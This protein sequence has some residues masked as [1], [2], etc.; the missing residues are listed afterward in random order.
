MKSASILKIFDRPVWLS[1]I[2]M[3]ASF[4]GCFLFRSYDYNGNLTQ[5]AAT[6]RNRVIDINPS[7]LL[8][9]PSLLWTIE[10]LGENYDILLIAQLLTAVYAAITVLGTFILLI[11][12]NGDR[13]LSFI[14]SLIF[15]FSY[16]I[17]WYGAMGYPVLLGFMPVPFYL[18][19]AVAIINSWK[20]SL[21]ILMLLLNVL[22]ILAY[23]SNLFIIVSVFIILVVQLK[24]R[25][26][27]MEI[28]ACF[29]ASAVIALLSFYLFFLA[30]VQR[31]K[32][33]TF[34]GWLL[35]YGGGAIFLEFGGFKNLTNYFRFIYQLPN[36][37]WHL[38]DLG[39][40]FKYFIAT[41]D[42]NIMS[43]AVILSLGIMVIFYLLIAAM[44]AMGI[45]NIKVMDRTN[46]I[47]CAAIVG[48]M[49]INIIFNFYWVIDTQI[50]IPVIFSIFL[51]G[52]V[53]L[54]AAKI[55][56]KYLILVLLLIFTTTWN[57]AN[58]IL[59]DHRN[60]S[61]LINIKELL[62]HTEEGSLIITP[63]GDWVRS[64]GI[65]FLTE[66]RLLTLYHMLASHPFYET[67][68]NYFQKLGASIDSTLEQG[69]PVY[70]SGL[71]QT[72]NEPK[73]LYMKEHY[74]WEDMSIRGYRKEDFITF[75]NQNYSLTT[76]FII[77]GMIFKKIARKQL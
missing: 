15:A 36:V 54:N 69:R 21:Y 64:F 60:R 51:L 68:E 5:M 55:K 4:T 72:D 43:W 18:A 31:P 53:V 19:L 9:Q 1:F 7:H 76:S 73:N 70:I 27:I 71:E 26:R 50:M 47:F 67:K 2:A 30:D 39:K 62:S 46:K 45:K 48:Y 29:A 57:F 38:V 66:R 42:L 14:S 33:I 58:G 52:I 49:I 44:V 17:W 61:G 8:F 11:V 10:L 25:K 63:G 34:M 28:A 77:D 6:V 65:Y 16:S 32:D 24:D 59:P 13:W 56:K 23:I 3:L 20:F 41:R 35:S 22:L 37:F 12:L 75:I 74:V 40:I